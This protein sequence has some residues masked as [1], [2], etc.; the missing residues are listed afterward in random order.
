MDSQNLQV[1]SYR[2]LKTACHELAHVFGL[3]HCPYYECLMN[4]SNLVE[5]S[6]RKP[7]SFCPLCLRKVSAYFNFN[8]GIIK[9]QQAI[10]EHFKQLK[11]SCFDHEIEKQEKILS[12]LKE[13][14]FKAN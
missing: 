11:N 12:V 10:V 5:E 8:D 3:T 1:I 2:C 7:F 9:R 14:G 4:G 6:D 13:H